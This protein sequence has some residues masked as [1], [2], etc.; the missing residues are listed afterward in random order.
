MVLESVCQDDRPALSRDKLI[1]ESPEYRS[2][3]PMNTRNF[4]GITI[5]LLT[6]WL[7]IHIHGRIFDGGSSELMERGETD[8]W[9]LW[10]IW[11]WSVPPEL[12]LT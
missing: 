5:A 4:G 7:G 8:A 6:T 10:G 1:Y 11:R 3:P 2:P 9:R 12:S